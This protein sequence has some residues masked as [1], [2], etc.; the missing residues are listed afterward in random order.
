MSRLFRTVALAAGLAVLLAWIGPAAPALAQ[1]APPAVA[2]AQPDYSWQDSLKRQ[3]GRIAL[4]DG[5]ASLD[6][7]DDYYFIGK[8]DARKVLVDGW[9]NPPN[10][11]DGVMGMIFPKRFKPMD[12]GSWGAVITFDPVGYVSDKDARTADYA[13]ILEDIKSADAADNVERKKQGFP[14]INVVG[15]AEPPKYL[16]DGHVVI[17]ARDLISS[18]SQNHSLN[19]DIRV[20]GR[21]GVLSLNVVAAM[22][23]LANVRDAADGIARTAV[24]DQG[25]QYADYKEGVDKAAGFGI[26]GLVAAG[27]GVAVAKKAGLLGLILL[28]GKKFLVLILAF[29]GGA[30]AWLR[31]LVGLKPKAPAVRPAPADFSE[32]LA[33][34]SAN[35]IEGGSKGGDLIS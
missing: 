21:E 34:P 13:K 10:A 9:G 32:P 1:G 5:K 33:S 14:E 26:A 20:L 35:P 16:P 23:D 25:Q 15:W 3:T 28:F 27:A 6:L 2:P 24:F 17:W 30:V 8:D 4:P 22:D 31:R 18:A 19:Y 12:E 7:G 29:F 11:V